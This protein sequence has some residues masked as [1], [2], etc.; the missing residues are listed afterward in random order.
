MYVAHWVETVLQPVIGSG[1]LAAA[2]GIVESARAVL[3]QEAATAASAT[4]QRYGKLTPEYR[5]RIAG[6]I[7]SAVLAHEVKPGEYV[8]FCVIGPAYSVV[9]G[10]TAQG[11]R[12]AALRGCVGILA[13]TQ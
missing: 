12:E 4:L 7:A 3:A 13:S 2:G 1:R 6:A 11:V 10:S 5:A 9:V 8:G